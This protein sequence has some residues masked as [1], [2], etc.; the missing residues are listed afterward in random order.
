MERVVGIGALFFRARDPG[1]LMEW[2]EEHLGFTE[3]GPDLPLRQAST[4]ASASK[5]TT[6][7][8]SGGL[9]ISRGTASSS[10][11]AVTDPAFTECPATVHQLNRPRRVCTSA[12]GSI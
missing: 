1:A 6:T 2:Y 3:E 4:S 5:S 12:R 10:G 11:T 8:G 7:A 9:T